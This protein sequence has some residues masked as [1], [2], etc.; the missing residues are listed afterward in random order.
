MTEPTKY[1]T[2]RN[3]RGCFVA[4]TRITVIIRRRFQFEARAVRRERER[5]GEEIARCVQIQLSNETML[6]IG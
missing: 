3:E 1:F 6:T 2:A 5:E 4:Q